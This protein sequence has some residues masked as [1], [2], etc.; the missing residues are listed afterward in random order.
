MR[1]GLKIPTYTV[2]IVPMAT[3][4]RIRNNLVFDSR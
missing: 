4:A 3:N 1:P 2:V